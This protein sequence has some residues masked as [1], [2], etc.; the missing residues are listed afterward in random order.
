MFDDFDDELIDEKDAPVAAS[1]GSS[2]LQP[3]RSMQDCIGHDAVEKALLEMTESGR[4]PH[5]I[6]FSGPQGIGK[7]TMAFRFARYLLKKGAGGG[8]SADG[9][10]FGDM[11]PKTVPQNLSVPPEDPIF[12]Q[13]ASG[14]HPGLLTIERLFDEKSNKL[15]NTVEVDEARRITPFM[16][17]TASDGGWRI[18]IV[19]DADTMNRSAQ[20]AILK[21][22]EEPPA[23]ALL[24]LIAHRLGA[25]LPTIRSRCRTVHFTAP[26]LENFSKLVRREHGMLSDSDMETL[27]SL[28][29]QSVGQ[30]VRICD[31]GGL[32]AISKVMTL[33]YSWPQWPWSQIHMLAETM[34]RQG[35]DDGLRTFQDVFL[36]IVNSLLRAKARGEALKSPLNNTATQQMLNSYSLKEWIEI[37]RQIQEHFDRVSAA[38]LDKRHAVLGAF[39]I[40]EA[41]EAA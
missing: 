19:D 34:G 33:L 39:S 41:K 38:S 15:K 30:A 32:E 8:E 26:N 36:W 27:Y 1:H 5:A 13:V 2:G 14:G 25:M 6:I 17:M 11:L 9:G 18:V 29:G 10:M 22:L 3:P 21:I 23:N 35:Q 31:E 12:R 40:F 20:N 28:S 4:M 37:S 24:I 7:A 16:R